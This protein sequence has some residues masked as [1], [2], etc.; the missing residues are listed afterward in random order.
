[1]IGLILWN[2]P[3]VA[4]SLNKPRKLCNSVVKSPVHFLRLAFV[5]P[6]NAIVIRVAKTWVTR[7]GG[8]LCLVGHFGNQERDATTAAHCIPF[9]VVHDQWQCNITWI[10]IWNMTQSRVNA[11]LGIT[12]LRAICVKT[13]ENKMLW[14]RPDLPHLVLLPKSMKWNKFRGLDWCRRDDDADNDGSIM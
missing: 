7:M 9:V 12:Y 10:W 5:N 6:W 8:A 4:P 13:A 3:H 11:P 14:F 2:Y 1:M